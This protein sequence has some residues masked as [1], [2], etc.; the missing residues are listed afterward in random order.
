MSHFGFQRTYAHA[1]CSFSWV[2]MNK[3]MLHFV[4]QCEVFQCNGDETIKS[5]GALQP[6]PIP[7]FIWTKISMDFIVGLPKDGNKYVIMV[8][9][10]SLS[11]YSHFCSLPHPLTPKLVEQ[12]FLDDILKLHGMPTSIVSNHDP[13]FT[14]K[15]VQSCLNYKAPK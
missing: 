6:L 5:S 13:T 3:D 4:M 11:K 15:F 14:I 2:G 1:H 12:V 8:V 9:V 10:D 7:T